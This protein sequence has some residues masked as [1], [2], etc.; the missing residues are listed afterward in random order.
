M[1]RRSDHT[2]PQLELLAVEEGWKMME[3]HGLAKFSARQLA[4]RIGYSVATV[5]HLFGSYEGLILRLNGHTLDIWYEDFQAQLANYRGKKPL[6]RIAN[7]YI[8]FSRAHPHAWLALFTH[9]MPGGKSL[10]DWYLEKLQRFFTWVEAMV[11]PLTNQP[12][13]AGKQARVLWAGIHG[14][15]MLSLTQKLDL[16]Y[17]PRPENDMAEKLAADLIEHYVRGLTQA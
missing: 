16:G 13:Q 14:I 5:T 3:E 6:Q 15:A 8:A 2:R 17:P 1:A 10:P 7:A 4:E 12:Q 11:L 9:E